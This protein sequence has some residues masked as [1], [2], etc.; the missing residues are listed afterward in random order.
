M[1]RA[2]PDTG[3]RGDVAIRSLVSVSIALW[4]FSSLV[5]P[6][7]QEPP[8]EDDKSATE[9]PASEEEKK[10]RKFELKDKGW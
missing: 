5:L 1:T 4:L 9:E 10:K 6:A 8:G 3:C 2:A 7:D